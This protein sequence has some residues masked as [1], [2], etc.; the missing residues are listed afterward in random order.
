MTT[1]TSA[2]SPPPYGAPPTR[3][4]AELCAVADVGD[5]AKAL[6][7]DNGA[8]PPP[9]TF[10]AMLMERDLHADAVRFLAHALPRREAVWWAW[11][12][13]RKVAGAEPAP[14]I[15]AALDATERWIVQPTEEHRRHALAAGEAAE[16]GT[17]AGCAALAAFMSSGSLAP[18]EA[19]MVPPGE[20]MTAKA[21]SGSVTL[22][23]VATEP[24]KAGAKFKEFVQLG[25]EVAERTK[26]WPA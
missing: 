18:P 22:A 11:V 10:V 23:A 15:K 5:E 21:V 9:K 4:T 6:L 1:P 13:A 26:L 16:F 25:I 3:G 19:P 24:D 20:F 14:P 8:A 2:G 7:P 12:C 17:S